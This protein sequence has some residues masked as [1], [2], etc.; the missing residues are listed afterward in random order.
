MD[1]SNKNEKPKAQTLVTPLDMNPSS[2]PKVEK[3][4]WLEET[5]DDHLN[6]VL[7]GSALRFVHKTDFVI[8]EVIEEAHCPACGVRNRQSSHRLQ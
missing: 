8:Q 6:C 5:L 4:A 3:K 7:C 2:L 1:T